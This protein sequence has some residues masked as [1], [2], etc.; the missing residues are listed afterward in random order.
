MMEAKGYGKKPILHIKKE[1][2]Q[3]QKEGVIFILGDILCIEGHTP[4]QLYCSY[5]S[6]KKS[7]INAFP[8][9]KEY[10]IIYKSEEEHYQY[11]KEYF[12][13]YYDNRKLS[14]KEFSCYNFKNPYIAKDYVW[15]YKNE[16]FS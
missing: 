8:V 3:Y 7:N 15:Y 9:P 13:K 5:A 1:L 11:L 6:S 4:F 16:T 2:I 12:R 14:R 10:H